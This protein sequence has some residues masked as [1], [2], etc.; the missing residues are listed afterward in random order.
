MR[1]IFNKLFIIAVLSAFV[2]GAGT[3]IFFAL[4]Q[5]PSDD[6]KALEEELVKIEDEI[7]KYESDIKKT[8]Q[9]KATLENKIYILKSQ[10]KKLDLQIY[11]TNVVIKDLTSQIGDTELSINNTSLKIE[12]SAKG[13]VEI[14]R[15]IYEEDQ[16]SLFEILISEGASEF[17]NNLV[18][19]ENLSERSKELL[20]DIKELKSYLEKQKQSLDDEKE[21]MGKLVIV[22]NLQ[23]QENEVKKMEQERIL[24]VTKGKEGEYQ[25]LLSS[26]QKRAQEIR[27]RIFD[28]I[29]VPE[30]PTFGEA[31]EMAKAV[32][33]QTG[34]RPALL[35]AVLTQ[36]SNIGKNVGQCF[37]SDS[38]TG[39]GVRTGSRQNIAKVMNPTRDVP[40]FLNITK[41]LGRDPYNTPVSCP[42]SSV[43]GYGGAMGPAQFIP[44]TWANYKDK[45]SNLIDRSPDPWNIKD[46]FLA[47]GVYLKELG[48][49][50]NEFR[51]V[52]RYFSGSSWSRYEEFYGRSVLAITAQYEKDIQELEK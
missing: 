28:L 15:A 5:I 17:F 26:A 51:A 37:L 33:R 10:I 29:G 27:S 48:V 36:E 22:S 52:M 21:E 25:K 32:Y 35:L 46:A 47:A 7:S 18:G 20:S 13:L 23:K 38:N 1:A 9:E 40:H 16:K 11:Q 30:A 42:I 31:Y 43:G 2:L 6:R 12:Q 45:I 50:N 14:L 19:L 41:G 24:D 49:L 3:P 44:S 34:V 4:A 39:S 8:E